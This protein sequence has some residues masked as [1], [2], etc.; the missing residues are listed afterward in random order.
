MLYVKLMYNNIFASGWLQYSSPQSQAYVTTQ[1]I[2]MNISVSANYYEQFSV[3]SLGLAWYHNGSRIAANDRV[4][5]ADN[6]TT[7]IIASTK[8]SD[9]GTYEV[10]IDSVNTSNGGSPE[11]DQFL[12]P[13]LE[14]FALHAPA[15]FLLQ[16]N[17]PPSY[18][19]EDL[20]NNYFIPPYMG[21]DQRTFTIHYTG[22]LINSTLHQIQ[23]GH[24]VHTYKNVQ[25]N[26]NSWSWSRYYTAENNSFT[27]NINYLNSQDVVGHYIQI[28]FLHYSYG[29]L[30]CFSHY[31][32]LM[33]YFRYMP[34]LIYYWTITFERKC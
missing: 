27:Y 34:F 6:G 1:T 16:Q 19:L 31:M 22:S 17:V 28:H 10:K 7:L 30:H 21:D 32:N 15:T 29:E 33:Y 18:S 4:N 3:A 5:I 24:D 14:N 26:S 11:C 9:A 13:L 20:I 25:Y 12:L 23:Y 2:A 8:N